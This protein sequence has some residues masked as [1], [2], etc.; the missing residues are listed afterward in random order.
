M[1]IYEVEGRGKKSGRARKRRYFAPNEMEALQRADEDDTAVESIVEIPQPDEPPTE[2]QLDYARALG[3]KVPLSATKLDVSDLIEEELRRRD[4]AILSALPPDVGNAEAEDLLRREKHKDKPI[5]PRHQN[6]ARIYD[7]PCTPYTGKKELFRRIHDA[8]VEPGRETEMVS[9]FVFRVY[10]EL[11]DGRLDLPI[12]SPDNPAIRAIGESL[13]N[14]STVVQSVRRYSGEDLIWF[15]EFTAPNGM[16]FNGGSRRT[17]AFKAAANAL[18]QQLKIEKREAGKA[19]APRHNT[20]SP[21]PQRVATVQR[22]PISRA[23]PRSQ[24][25]TPSLSTPQK[26]GLAVIG[27][28][29]L[30][31]AI[32]SILLFSYGRHPVQ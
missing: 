18:Q 17:A 22:R 16:L 3:I 19:N 31:A 29:F 32:V 21:H 28:V 14:D 23:A 25:T 13:A 27:A 4:A 26:I 12:D 8:L 10:R 5:T 9:W 7:V 30:W 2:R 20:R 11:N 1:R 15:G 24:S 6:F